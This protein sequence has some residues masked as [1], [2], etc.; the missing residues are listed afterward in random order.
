MKLR[1]FWSALCL[2]A[3]A[4][5]TFVAAGDGELVYQSVYSESLKNNLLGDPAVLAGDSKR[6][7]CHFSRKSSSPTTPDKDK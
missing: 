2:S 5:G 6:R 4:G 1:T 7:H 3:S